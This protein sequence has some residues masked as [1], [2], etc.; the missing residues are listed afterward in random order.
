MQIL[1]VLE[2]VYWSLP[3]FNHIVFP[4]SL[5]IFP[6][7]PHRAFSR[8][9]G[10][11]DTSHVGSLQQSCGYLIDVVLMH[12]VGYSKPSKFSQPKAVVEHA[13]HL[14]QQFVVFIC[15]HFASHSPL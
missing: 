7:L 2:I 5:Q 9:G 4:H 14:P 15:G 3:L 8:N 10:V 1:W 11:N 13:H 6:Q 12:M